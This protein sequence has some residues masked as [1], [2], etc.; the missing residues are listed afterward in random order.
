MKQGPM[1]EEKK[2]EGNL[3]QEKYRYKFLSKSPYE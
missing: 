3:E 1:N 2:I